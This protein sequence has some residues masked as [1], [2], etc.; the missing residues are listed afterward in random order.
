MEKIAFSFFSGNSN[1]TVGAWS[2]IHFCWQSYQGQQQY[3]F[4]STTLALTAADWEI[5]Y[6]KPP[7]EFDCKF[8]MCSRMS[9][10]TVDKWCTSELCH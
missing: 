4:C 5:Q 8:E 3:T 9:E 10:D 2:S 7:I 6:H 1:Y